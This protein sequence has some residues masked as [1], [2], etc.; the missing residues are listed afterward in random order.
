MGSSASRSFT[1][2]S[3]RR[4]S[5]AEDTLVLPLSL[6]ARGAR[7]RRGARGRSPDSRRGAGAH[8]TDP[9]RRPDL[10]RP[11][12]MAEW[13]IRTRRCGSGGGG[14]PLT[15]AGPCRI[16]TGFP[17]VP[18]F[19]S[20]WA[21]RTTVELMWRANPPERGRMVGP[22]ARAWQ[23]AGR[24]TGAGPARVHTLGDEARAHTGT[25]ERVR[26]ARRRDHGARRARL[27]RTAQVSLR[28]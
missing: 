25:R 22:R 20:R 11:L 3:I 28:T 9:R 19:L 26:P 13:S 16:H 8:R 14:S 4:P 27:A 21:P 1:V 5:K 17:V 15:V 6:E 7:S 10:P 23:G 12:L 2:T 18:R 24:R